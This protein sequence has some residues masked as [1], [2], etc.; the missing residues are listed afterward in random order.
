MILRR[1]QPADAGTLRD[2]FA[3][4]YSEDFFDRIQADEARIPEISFV[5]L[6]D[7]QEVIGHV[8]A[9]R[10]TVDDAPVLAL[11]PPSVDPDQRGRGAGQ[12]LMHTVLG[13][14]EAAGEPLVGVVATPPEWFTQ[15]GFGSG[16]D[17]SIT[18]SVGGWKPYFQIRP[19]TAFD[20]M[21]PSSATTSAA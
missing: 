2:L 18:P 19:L 9:S 16:D 13:A 12:A 4:V 3:T 14:A 15:F 7:D 17:Y 5:A 6:G 8:G 10:G 1:Q 21:R 20:P 11:V